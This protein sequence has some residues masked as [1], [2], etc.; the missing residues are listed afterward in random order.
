M[1]AINRQN[2]H[3]IQKKQVAF[4]GMIMMFDLSE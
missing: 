2:E 4:N 1:F 3:F